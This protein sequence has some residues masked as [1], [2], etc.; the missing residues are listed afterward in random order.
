MAQKEK[1]MA[2]I[3]VELEKDLYFDMMEFCLAKR[4]TLEDFVVRALTEFAKNNKP[5]EKSKKA[6]K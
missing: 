3:T 4:E 2:L 5:A 1:E 6:L